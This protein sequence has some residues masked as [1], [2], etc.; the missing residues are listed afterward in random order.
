MAS[1]CNQQHLRIIRSL[2][3]LWAHI[4]V[5]HNS[6]KYWPIFVHWHIQREICDIF[7]EN[8]FRRFFIKLFKFTR[9][10]AQLPLTNRASTMNFFVAKLLAIA[11]MIYSYVYHFRSLRSMIRL[12]CYAHTANKLSMPLS[13]D[14]SFLENPCRYPHKLYIARNYRVSELHYSCYSMGLSVFYVIDFKSQEKIFKT[15]VN[16]RP[17][18]PLTSSF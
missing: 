1:L 6:A 15:S 9:Q 7:S 17:H 2:S 13:F 10:E 12:I 14:V 18:C 3:T 16:A 11:V 4:N 8:H 5:C